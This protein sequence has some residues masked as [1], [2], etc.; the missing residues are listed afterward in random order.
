MSE[1]ATQSDSRRACV[2]A[3]LGAESTGKST[4]ALELQAA[5]AQQGHDVGLV[6]E[7]LREFC[8]RHGRTPRPQEQAGIVDEQSWRIEQAAANHEIVICDTTALMPAVYSEL[9]FSDNRLYAN[10]LERQAS[11]ALNLLMAIDLPW[12]ADGVQR[13][14]AH[15]QQPVD[16]RIRQ[17]LAQAKLPFSVVYGSGDLRLGNA[18]RC[19]HQSP[20]LRAGGQVASSSSRWQHV[21]ERCGDP[22]CERHLLA[23]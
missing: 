22:D 20:G 11:Y 10:A 21:C 15:V 14:G 5:L 17:A 7:F 18:L 4:L 8:D 19:V 12:K 1:T 23:S 2:I 13:D 6:K 3:L 9:L 16:Q